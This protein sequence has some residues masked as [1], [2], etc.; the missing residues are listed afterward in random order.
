MTS[1]SE[2]CRWCRHLSIKHV[3]PTEK[4]PPTAE[5]LC[6]N[7]SIKK[8]FE[9]QN[10][11]HFK[12]KKDS[13]KTIWNSKF[14]SLQIKNKNNENTHSLQ[15]FFIH[16]VNNFFFAFEKFFLWLKIFFFD[17]NNFFG[18]EW[19]RHKCPTHVWPK[20]KKDYFNQREHFQLKQKVFK[21][22]FWSL[23]YFICI[24]KWFSIFE[25]VY[26]FIEVTFVLIL[27]FVC[28]KQLLFWLNDKDTNVL[29]IIWSNQ[30]TMLL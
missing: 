6:Q 9:L 3:W 22:N 5:R 29:P 10:F 2:R 23:K 19:L 13:I 24:Q 7:D 4:H 14:F 26:L 18:I 8:K 20:H 15:Y 17:W 28:L 30:K 11:L 1:L 16:E 21:C 27:L 12:K 25:N